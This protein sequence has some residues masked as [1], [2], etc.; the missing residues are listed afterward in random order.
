MDFEALPRLRLELDHMK[1]TII[2]HLGIHG[3]EL[4]G[5]INEK[6]EEVIANYDFD[7]E[8]SRIA[9]N[10]I[11]E[12]IEKEFTSGEGAKFIQNAINEAFR[13][14]FFANNKQIETKEE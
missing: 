13:K 3:S 12:A 8:I 5:K 1:S 7:G 11:T 14:M 10:A 9:S 4:S 2:T 6:I